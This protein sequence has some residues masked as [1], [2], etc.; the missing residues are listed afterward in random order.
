M[1]CQVKKMLD[2][3]VKLL[4]FR[5]CR[6]TTVSSKPS[7]IIFRPKRLF[8]ALLLIGYNYNNLLYVGFKEGRKDTSF[9][10]RAIVNNGSHIQLSVT[11]WPTVSQQATDTLP[12]VGRHY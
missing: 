3:I 11:C 12:T 6:V 8:P 7:L 4:T 5:V 9:A 1:L 10:V 2:S